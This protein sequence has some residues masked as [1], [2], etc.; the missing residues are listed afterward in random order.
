MIDKNKL[1][2]ELLQYLHNIVEL[3]S[4]FIMYKTIKLDINGSLDK[5]NK[6]PY[7]FVTI[8]NGLEYSFIMQSY[9]LFDSTEDK[10]LK[11]MIELCKNNQKHFENTKDLL[12]ELKQFEDYLSSQQKIIENISGMRN[13]FFGHSDRKYFKN[14]SQALKDYSVDNT[15]YENLIEETYKK[16]KKIYSMLQPFMMID[17]VEQMEKNWNKLIEKI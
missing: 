9:K 17:W 7:M 2:E 14:P 5:V 6:Y 16:V 13:K 3:R 10:T 4:T 11:T 8:I 12:V 1:E 15:E